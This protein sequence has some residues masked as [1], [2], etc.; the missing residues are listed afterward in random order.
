MIDKLEA[1]YQKMHVPEMVMPEQAQLVILYGLGAF[2]AVLAIIAIRMSLR[3]KDWT[4][5]VFLVAGTLT[6]LTTEALSDLLTHFTHAQIG[7]ITSASRC[8]SMIGPPQERA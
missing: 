7:A 2:A 6:S 4:P 8:G 3:N 5:L 1:Q